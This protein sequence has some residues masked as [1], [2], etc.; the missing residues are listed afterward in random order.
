MATGVILDPLFTR[1]LTA[2][3]HPERPERIVA[4][5]EAFDEWPQREAVTRY[6]PAPIDEKWI[7]GVHSRRHYELIESTRGQQTSLL[8]A[9]TPTGPDSF[10]TALQAAGS[11]VRL[12]EAMAQNEVD[13]AFSLARPPGHHAESERAMGFCL[14]NNSAIAANWAIANGVAS[15]VAIVD[16]DVHHGNGTQEIFYSRPD[17]LYISS[18]QFPFYPGTGE[19]GELGEGH[20]LGYTVN[21][22]LRAGTGDSFYSS[23]YRDLVTPIL[24][25]YSP[26][27][28]I[29]S[30]GYDA[31]AED[32]LG[33][34]LMSVEGYG[35]LVSILQ[36]AAG[37]AGAKIAYLLEGGYNL[38]ALAGSVLRS[39][40]VTL[41]PGGENVPDIPPSQTVEYEA[42]R[43]IA[44]SYLSEYWRC[45]N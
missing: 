20:G 25:E 44:K 38:N 7:V 4:L 36:G 31:H 19:F 42:Y 9:D 18:H 29:V 26:D 39:I 45:L 10:E 11:L 43:E 28:I 3:G 14:F 12:V 32:P 16:F 30:A 33:G 27:L 17:V 40:E 23:L 2:V 15:K 24:V 6:E 37:E 35:S 34:M 8:D 22:P 5:I 41:K 21:L 1:H 13:A